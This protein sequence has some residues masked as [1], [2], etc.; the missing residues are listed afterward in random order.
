MGHGGLALGDH[1][2][3]EVGDHGDVPTG[4]HEGQLH[5][6]GHHEVSAVAETA[7][8]FLSMRF[9]TFGLMTFGLVGT[10][11]HYLDLAGLGLSLGLSLASGLFFGIAAACIFR[12]LKGGVSSATT[13]DDTVGKL[14]KVTVPVRKGGIGKVRVQ[15]KGQTMDLLATTESD[16][17]APGDEVVVVEFRG[18]QALVEPLAGRD[19]KRYR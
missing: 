8:L 16:C 11:L 18:E 13:M 10:L 15:M 2:G 17:I 5:A 19:A 6:D 7:G 3:L 14:G 9:W 4:G 1:G 12:T